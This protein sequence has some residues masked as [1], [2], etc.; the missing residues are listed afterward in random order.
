MTETTKIKIDELSDK[1]DKSDT[2][3]VVKDLKEE[4]K[5]ENVPKCP[6][7]DGISKGLE[8]ATATKE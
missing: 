1:S 8:Y 4:G 5:V 7:S 3:G 2:F 6:Q